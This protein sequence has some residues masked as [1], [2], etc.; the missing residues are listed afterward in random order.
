MLFEK[1]TDKDR[2]LIQHYLWTYAEN[3]GSTLYR[4]IAPLDKIQHLE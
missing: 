3:D 2:D 1:L 4:D